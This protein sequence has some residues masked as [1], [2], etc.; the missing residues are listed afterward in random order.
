MRGGRIEKSLGGGVRAEHHVTGLLARLGALA[1]GFSEKFR[2]GDDGRT[3]RT[4]AV[5]GYHGPSTTQ[6]NGD[7]E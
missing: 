4:A 3:N 7:R 5:W 1:H 2:D 6:R